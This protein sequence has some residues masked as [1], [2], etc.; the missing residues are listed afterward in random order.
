[1]CA[2]AAEAYGFPAFLHSYEHLDQAIDL[3][4]KFNDWRVPFQRKFNKALF[5][6][7][8]RHA[9]LFMNC[10]IFYQPYKLYTMIS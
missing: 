4:V 5:S 6:G 9:E 7:V 8:W 1:M 10:R 2:P 3:V